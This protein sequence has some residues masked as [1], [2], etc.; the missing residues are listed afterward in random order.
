VGATRPYVFRDG[1]WVRI[2]AV[3]L[4]HLAL[5]LGCASIV[6]AQARKPSSAS[7]ASASKLLSIKVK[8]S[9]RYTPA[10]VIAASGLQLG[11]TVNDED[12]KGVS[13]H[14][15]ESGAFS[16][17]AY[18]FQF[19]AEGIKV[20]L[21]VTDSNPFVPVRFE[22]F[23]W[24]SD[25]ELLQKLSA[26]EPLFQGELPVGGNL[27]DQVSEALQGLAIERKLSGRVD[28]LRAGTQ[29]SPT[30]AFEFSITSQPIVVRKIDFTGAGPAELPT[31]Q[32]AARR[33]TGRDYSRSE[34]VLQAA[35]EFLPVFLQHGY[36]KATVGDPQPKV[37]EETVDET[38]VDVTF[39]VAPGLQYKVST[40][41]LSG[42]SNVFPVE[43]L[44]ELIRLK[45]G[46]TADAVQT[47]QD[48]DALKRLYGSRGYMGVEIRTMPEM[49][50][51][52]STVKYI[53][54]FEEGSIYKM[55]DLEVR[56]LDSKA[57]ERIGVAW[58]LQAGQTYDSGYIRVFLAS[59]ADQFPPDQWRITYRETPEDQDKV[60]D[61][62]LRFEAIR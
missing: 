3:K 49:N 57:S 24:F 37:V 7:S 38:A 39:A 40:I 59:I 43:K 35:K 15:G 22:N 9:K 12:L 52:D 54:Q 48:V 6:V 60:V 23:V 25:Q 19:T 20:D 2:A 55:G 33:L 10:Q 1:S 14:L 21:Q 8:G 51:A 44:R 27:A 29:D 41:Q 56:G 32:I 47:V 34:L 58:K 46:Q 50:D 31:L 17:V 30:E 61:V 42:Y 45:P 16:D 62:S 26:R 28:Y 4:L 18:S 13:Q 11:Q 36:L 53:F 5:L